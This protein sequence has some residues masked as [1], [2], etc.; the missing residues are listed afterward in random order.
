MAYSLDSHPSSWTT[1]ASPRFNIYERDRS[2]DEVNSLNL[3]KEEPRGRVLTGLYQRFLGALKLSFPSMVCVLQKD[4]ILTIFPFQGKKAIVD[5]EAASSLSP[6]SFEPQFAGIAGNSFYHVHSISKPPIKFSPRPVKKN[7]AALVVK[8]VYTAVQQPSNQKIQLLNSFPPPPSQTT[9]SLL[10][11]GTG[12]KDPDLCQ[13]LKEIL[14]PGKTNKR[15]GHVIKIWSWLLNF[16]P[17]AADE[18][19][20]FLDISS[21]SGRGSKFDF[22]LYWSAWFLLKSTS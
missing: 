11:R 17:T 16:I 5:I 14:V 7:P 9:S 8:P 15:D 12:K 13:Q 4:Y 1:I 18:F 2:C 22:S 10:L 6:H 20:V 21:P 19:Y 3:Q